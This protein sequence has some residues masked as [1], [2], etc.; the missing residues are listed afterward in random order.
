MAI[1]YFENSLYLKG[2]YHELVCEITITKLAYG[3]E[4]SHKISCEMSHKTHIIVI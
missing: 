1:M 3:C 4:I 2:K